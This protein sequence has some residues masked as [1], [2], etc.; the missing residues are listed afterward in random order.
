MDHVIIEGLRTDTVIGVHDWEREI[1]Q[2][3]VVDVVMD[4]DCH[5]AGHSDHLSDALDYDTVSRRL[6]E[7]IGASRLQLIEALA[8][9]CAAMILEEFPVR[10]LKLTLRKPGAVAEAESVGVVIHR[11]RLGG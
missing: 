6:L 11:S 5:D 4:Y 1:R 7:I 10:Q 8:E 3:V 2:E 9:R